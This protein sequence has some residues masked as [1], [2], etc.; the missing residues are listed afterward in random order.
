MIDDELVHA[1]R[2]RGLTPDNPVLRGTAQNP[3]VFF[4]ARESVNPYYLA[5]P[6]IVQEAMDRF[7]EL[8][9]RQYHLFDYIGAPDAEDILVLMGSGSDAVRETVDHLV[10]QGNKVGA[11]IVRL[12]R[13]FDVSAFVEAL[14][15]TVKKISVLDRTKEPGAAGEPLYLDVVTAVVERVADG[16][17]PFPVMP[18]I[19]GGPL[20]AI[21]KRV[22]T[23]HDQRRLR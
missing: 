13:P 20:R 1:H 7:A 9:G 15:P 16:Q 5:C 23:G 6:G 10:A 19:T 17:A 21:L 22:Y 3:D 4:Q 2:A 11:V 8:T 18:R 12:Y 14:P